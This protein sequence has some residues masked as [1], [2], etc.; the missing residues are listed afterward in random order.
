[1]FGRFSLNQLNAMPT[2]TQGYTDDL[3]FND[4]GTRT[5]VWLSRLDETDGADYPNQVT[6][7]RMVKGKDGSYNWQTIDEY[8]ATDWT[9]YEPTHPFVRDL[10]VTGTTTL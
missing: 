5:R 8:Q 2:I 7:E 6:V 3:K 1:M 9:D 4:E 10:D